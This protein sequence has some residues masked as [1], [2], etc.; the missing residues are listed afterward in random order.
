MKK[1]Y[2]TFVIAI[3]MIGC[4]FV[5]ATYAQDVPAPTVTGNTY[6]TTIYA[7]GDKSFVS[8]TFKPTGTFVVTGWNGSGSYWVFGQAFAGVYSGIDL[9]FPGF[10]GNATILVVGA[11]VSATS[12]LGVGYVIE[13]KVGDYYYKN[14]P[15]FFSGKF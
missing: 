13:E 7:G 9:K 3:L 5:T 2:S 10:V 1:L 15:F 8:M 11:A 14:F 6:L 12:V 4:T